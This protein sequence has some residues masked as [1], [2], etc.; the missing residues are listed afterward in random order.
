MIIISLSCSS[1]N[2]QRE[3]KVHGKGYKGLI[4]ELVCGLPSL[5]DDKN[6]NTSQHSAIFSC[7]ILSLSRSS[8]GWVRRSTCCGTSLQGKGQCVP[9]AL[10][11]TA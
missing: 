2:S 5:G 11:P 3:P 7:H 9:P 6:I 1:E 10:S 4:L 8:M